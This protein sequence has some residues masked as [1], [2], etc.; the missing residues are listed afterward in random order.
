M[1]NDICRSDGILVFIGC[2][3]RK[4]INVFT[5]AGVILSSNEDRRSVAFDEMR[6]GLILKLNLYVIKGTFG[7]PGGRALPYE[8]ARNARRKI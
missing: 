2:N 8:K 4:K 6:F 3:N 1:Q 5:N 7:N